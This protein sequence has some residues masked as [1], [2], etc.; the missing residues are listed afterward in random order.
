MDYIKDPLL[1][2]TFRHNFTFKEPDG[3][4]VSVGVSLAGH[5]FGKP[6]EIAKAEQSI[7]ENS[8]KRRAFMAQPR[9]VLLEHYLNKLCT[10]VREVFQLAQ[11]WSD[12][13]GTDSYNQELAK[14]KSEVFC[15]LEMALL[16]VPTLV[17]E[18]V[19][20]E[21]VHTSSLH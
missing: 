7:I 14:F 16:S 21:N 15:K 9:E 12:G 11:T 13:F 18:P 4:E 8:N 3:N 5:L 6:D 17:R 1:G 19:D 10:D 2:D 20:N